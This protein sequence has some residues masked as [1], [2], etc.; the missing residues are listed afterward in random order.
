MFRPIHVLFV[1]A[2]PLAAADTLPPGAVVRLGSAP[3][4]HRGVGRD[5]PQV[6]LPADGRTLYAKSAGVV[7]AWDVETGNGLWEW[8]DP[9]FTRGPI[10]LSPDG[11]RLAACPFDREQKRL[12]AHVYDVATRKLVWAARLGDNDSPEVSA[13]WFTPDGKRLITAALGEVWVWDAATGAEVA[14]TPVPVRSGGYRLSPDGRTIAVVGDGTSY[15]WEWEKKAPPRAFRT[16]RSLTLSFAPDS[17]SAIVTEGVRTLRRYD[18]ATGRGLPDV[19]FGGWVS[20]LQASS[21]GKTAA[22]WYVHSSLPEPRSGTVALW[23]LA[24]GKPGPVLAAAGD[25]LMSG[26]WSR[27]G[28]RFAGSNGERIFVWDAATGKRLGPPTVG[29]TRGVRALAF[30]PGGRV[31]TA[32]IDHTVRAWDAKTGEPL[33]RFDLAGWVGGLAVSPD[34]TLVAA[35]ATGNDLRVWDAKTGKEVFK[36]LGHGRM[37]GKRLVRFSADEQ[38]LVAYGDD[39]YLRAWDTL[40]GKLKSEHRLL[41]PLPNHLADLDPDDDD[42]RDRLEEHVALGPDGNTLAKGIGNEVVVYAADTG[43]ERLRFQGDPVV[44]EM[45]AFSPDGGRLVLAGPGVEFDVQ[46]VRPKGFFATVWDL[47]AAKAVARIPLPDDQYASQ[48]AFTPDGKRVVVGVYNRPL[49]FF[50]AATG[51]PAGTIELPGRPDAIAFDGGGRMAVALP[52]TTT[53]IYDLVAALKK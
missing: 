27:D 41:P 8:K 44:V 33:M 49:R 43:K 25:W 53:L 4:Q 42:V 23:D 15:L 1:L 18:L 16:A 31:F 24:A 51:A 9:P 14:Y 20:S 19:D 45:L 22:I 6:H 7:Y 28:R 39:F 5:F 11:T 52:D 2:L 38:T 12:S 32:S 17:R 46:N 10:A 47:K 35:S 13:L 36:L 21:D 34:G 26:T 3:F 29:H 50:D 37:G 48:L 30:G 40:T